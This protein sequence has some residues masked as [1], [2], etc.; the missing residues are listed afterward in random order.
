MFPN[1]KAPDDWGFFL[2]VV[3]TPDK[4]SAKAKGNG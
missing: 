2:I 4:K 1:N 3:F